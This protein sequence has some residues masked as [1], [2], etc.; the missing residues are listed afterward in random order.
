MLLSLVPAGGHIVTT[1]D[2]YWRTRQFMQQFLPKM[3]IGVSVIKP[4]DFAAL[5]EALDAHNVT[6]FFR[7]GF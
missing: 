4:N 3:N 1:S 7:L 6:L 2:C 5:K